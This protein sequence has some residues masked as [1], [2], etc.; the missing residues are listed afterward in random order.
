M[1]AYE[2]ISMIPQ[3]A[4]V[5]VLSSNRPRSRCRSSSRKKAQRLAPRSVMWRGIPGIS[6]W[7]CCGMS[8]ADGGGT[9]SVLAW[10]CTQHPGYATAQGGAS[11][12][13]G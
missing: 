4:G 8:E 13:P 2:N 7:A 5:P 11:R 12:I 1:I 3:A 9:S 10:G 6:R